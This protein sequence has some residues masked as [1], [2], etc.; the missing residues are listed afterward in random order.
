MLD[1]MDEGMPT[2]DGADEDEVGTAPLFRFHN[3][4]Q[5]ECVIGEVTGECVLAG[6]LVGTSPLREEDE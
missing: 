5:D 3:C 1:G 2:F 6:S 4:W